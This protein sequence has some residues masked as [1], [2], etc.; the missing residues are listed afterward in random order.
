MESTLRKVNISL[1]L[2]Q[3]ILLYIGCLFLFS[4]PCD[5]FFFFDDFGVEL[6]YEMPLSSRIINGD[7]VSNK[8]FPWKVAIMGRQSPFKWDI[9]RVF[10]VKVY[11]GASILNERWLITA[12][13]CFDSSHN[14][15]PVSFRNPKLWH[16]RVGTSILEA[17]VMEKMKSYIN[18]MWNKLTRGNKHQAY[19]H[20]EK[21]I[22]HPGFAVGVLENDIAL[23]KLKEKL[24]LS[25]TS[26]IESIPLPGGLDTLWPPQD[27]SCT[28]VGWGCTV[29]DGNVVKIA[30]H[31]SLKVIS[32][33]TCRE[34]Y[35]SNINLTEKI[36]FC[37]GSFYTGV[38]ICPGDS[39]SALVCPKQNK[40]VLAGITSATHGQRPES[41]PGLFTRVSAFLPWIQRVMAS[42]F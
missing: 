33:Q 27:D 41:Y 30:R 12:A 21:I 13:H 32:P 19:Y 37:A 17:N 7:A 36:E 42:N 35:R 38:G 9:M 6:R 29:V 28:V 22:L 2:R 23:V 20:F 8:Q 4:T 10:S 39:G 40:W 14:G 18:R 1:V 15:K 34:Y 5:G 26:G 3:L 31:T 24:P 11:C 25:I 16:A